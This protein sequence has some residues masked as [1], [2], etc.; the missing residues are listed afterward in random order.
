MRVSSRDELALTIRRAL[1][2]PGVVIV[3]IPVDYS[4]NRELGQH[5]LPN[6]WD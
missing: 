3:D 2:M 6:S 4:A 1:E 5:V